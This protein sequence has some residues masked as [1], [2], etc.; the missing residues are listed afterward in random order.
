VSDEGEIRASSDSMLRML[1]RLRAIEVDKRQHP[2]GSTEFIELASEVERLSRLVFRWSGLQLQ[3][4]DA[5]ARLVR[6][7][8]MPAQPISAIQP[9]S[10]DRILAAWREAQ[11]R[12]EIAKPGSAEAAAAADDLERLRE[13]YQV[14]AATKYADRDEPGDGDVAARPGIRRDGDGA[15]HTPVRRDGR[16]P[17]GGTAESPR[18]S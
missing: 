6:E 4:A 12:F 14:T 13:E 17:D 15:D 9:R 7:G 16:S 1:E 5:S 18:L 11:I 10:L 2:L 3:M 8:G